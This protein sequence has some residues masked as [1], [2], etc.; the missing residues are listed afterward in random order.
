VIQHTVSNQLHR[1]GVRINRNKIGFRKS[2][3]IDFVNN[4]EYLGFLMHLNDA[5]WASG[6][7]ARAP[8][9]RS[10]GLSPGNWTRISMLQASAGRYSAISELRSPPRPLSRRAGSG[11]PAR[12]GRWAGAST[13]RAIS[14]AAAGMRRRA[15]LRGPCVLRASALGRNSQRSE[16]GG[17]NACNRPFGIGRVHS[18]GNLRTAE[19]VAAIPLAAQQSALDPRRQNVDGS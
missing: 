6:F 17:Q 7:A 1:F 16:H 12:R 13:G 8:I 10:G 3:S 2:K 19:A 14:P 9:V 5:A 4:F 11:S 18:R 15:R